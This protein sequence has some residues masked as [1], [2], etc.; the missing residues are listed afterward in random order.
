[1]SFSA[2][3]RAWKRHASAGDDRTL[4]SHR[5]FDDLVEDVRRRVQD[6]L[7]TVRD[8]LQVRRVQTTSEPQGQYRQCGEL[9]AV[10][11]GRGDR[12]LVAARVTRAMSASAA[13]GDSAP[14]V[15]PMVRAPQSAAQRIVSRISLVPPDWEIATARTPD[16]STRAPLT[17]AMDGALR[18]ARYPVCA[19][20]K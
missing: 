15:M 6:L 2:V 3:S 14:L 17:V 13:K 16:R 8:A 9:G 5:T 10:G 1:M 18:V 4:D 11:L 7:D 12:D 20:S 19:C